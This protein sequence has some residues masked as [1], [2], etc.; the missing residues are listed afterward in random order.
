MIICC[1]H[2]DAYVIKRTNLDWC[3]ACG[4][5]RWRP[6][7]GDNWLAS[8]LYPLS[9]VDERSRIPRTKWRKGADGLARP[10]EPASNTAN[11]R[12]RQAAGQPVSFLESV[13]ADPYVPPVTTIMLPNGQSFTAAEWAAARD[14][15]DHYKLP[16]GWEMLV[17]AE[18]LAAKTPST[19]KK[20]KTKS[21]KPR[22]TRKSRPKTTP[23]TRKA[24]RKTR[25]R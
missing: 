1:Q 20:R 19:R 2:P 5:L 14:A 15:D 10:I 9:G 17:F 8:A 21:A 7:S 25:K 16:E 6:L 3:T 4:S 24:T 22:A 18:A 12:A 11:V 13:Q 23:T